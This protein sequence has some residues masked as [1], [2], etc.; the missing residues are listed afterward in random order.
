LGALQFGSPDT[1]HR[2]DCAPRRRQDNSQCGAGV[3]VA[4]LLE[5]ADPVV[6]SFGRND[7]KKLCHD[8]LSRI[9]LDR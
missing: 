4:A 3:L 1:A 2:R 9:E 5:P 8:A 6:G 7:E